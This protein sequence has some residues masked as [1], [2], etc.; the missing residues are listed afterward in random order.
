MRALLINSFPAELTPTIVDLPYLDCSDWAASSEMLQSKYA[1]GNT[2]RYLIHPP[3]ETTVRLIFLSGVA[4]DE[5]IASFDLQDLPYLGVR[6]IEQALARHLSERG[7]DVKQSRFEYTALRKREIFNDV[8]QLHSGISYKARRP[9][10]ANPYGYVLSVQWISRATFTESLDNESLCNIS[11]GLGTLYTPKKAPEAV[12]Q[13]YTDRY[14][15]RIKEVQSDQAIVSCKDGILRSIPLSDL[16][17]EAST[18]AIRR[19]ELRTG[20]NQQRSRV[21][22]QLLQLSQ[23]LTPSGRRNTAVLRDRLSAIQ[24][25][26][27]FRSREDLFLPLDSYQAGH[28]RVNLSPLQVEVSG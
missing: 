22:R 1:G 9:F 21:V 19:F 18:E 23:V 25:F 28:V 2:Y 15:G 7:L 13:E 5:P 3:A 20:S 8:I 14:V 6:L 24:R 4:P 17:L 11:Q 26:L 27:G 16:T 12:L 10:A